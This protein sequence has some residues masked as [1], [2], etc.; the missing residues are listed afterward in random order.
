MSEVLQFHHP[1]VSEL[2]ENARRA[3][4]AIL[5]ADPDG[6]PA[7]LEAELYVYRDV[8]DGIP[9]PYPEKPPQI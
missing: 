6:L 2:L 1:E 5:L 4:I 3:A 9:D 7:S 8:L